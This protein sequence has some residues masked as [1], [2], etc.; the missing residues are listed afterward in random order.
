MIEPKLK[1]T[2]NFSRMTP[3]K[4]LKRLELSGLIF[5]EFLQAPHLSIPAHAHENATILCL[6]DGRVADGFKTRVHECKT[7]SMLVRPAG[8]L[9]SHRYGETGAHCLAIQITRPKIEALSPFSQI[10]DGVAHL[11][12]SRLFSLALLIR[13]ELRLMDDASPI[14]IEGLALEMLARAIRLNERTK[15]AAPPYWLGRV[16]ELIHEHYLEP[17]R[18]SE[19]ARVAGVHQAHVAE[20]FRKHFHCTIAEY[21]R[22]MRLDAAVRELVMTDKPLKEIALATGFYDQS[23][24][25]NTLKNRRGLTPTEIRR[26]TN[27]AKTLPKSLRTSKP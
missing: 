25:G 26:L 27:R 5:T 3:T 6:Y 15:S 12:D 14:A 21:I 11:C 22:D 1:M 16:R 9:H 17:W 23:H 24:L 8:E 7:S 18:L 2:H 19:I 20:S 13:K 4:E 10:L